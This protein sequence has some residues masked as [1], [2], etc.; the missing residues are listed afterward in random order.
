M[1]ETQ[2][3]SLGLED[4]LEE[5][6]ATH[7]SILA[8]RIPWTEEPGGLYSPWGSQSV[9][10]NW[11]TNAFTFT[12]LQKKK[13]QDWRRWPGS[14]SLG[15]KTRE[16]YRETLICSGAQRKLRTQPTDNSSDPKEGYSQPSRSA[17]PR[18]RPC[19]GRH[20][21]LTQDS[22]SVLMLGL[23]F[24]VSSEPSQGAQWSRLTCQCRR[25]KRCRFEPWVQKIPWRR[26]RQPTPVFLPG[27]SQGQRSLG[28]YSPQGG[29]VGHDWS[30]WAQ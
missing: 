11:S 9:R 30:D 10:P 29:R 22:V 16:P 5:G 20:G 25:Q 4:P 28:G 18:S 24:L 3:W 19:L 2:V 21:A 8:W 15:L 12:L 7:S 6:M 14:W 26:K 17:V 13:I 23:A 27:K 1:Q